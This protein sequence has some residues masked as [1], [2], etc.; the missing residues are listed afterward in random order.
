MR[1]SRVHSWKKVLAQ[2]MLLVLPTVLFFFYLLW[3]LNRFYTILE[4]E[5]V[6][7]GCYFMAGIVITTVFYAYRF[8]F[9]TTAALLLIFYYLIYKYVGSISL[10][11]FDA[12]YLSVQFIVFV[13]LFSLGWLAGFG[14]S[15]SKY[16]TVF[17]SILLLAMQIVVVSKTTDIKVNLLISSFA[18]VLAYA[19][20]I[21]YTAELIRNM[22]EDETHFSS[23]I[24]RRITG[25]LLVLLILF[26]A[27]F[28]IFR[29][30]FKAVEKEWGNSQAKYDK[31]DSKSENMNEKDKDGGIGNKDQTKLSGSLSK[32][33]QLVFV[34]KLDNYFDDNKT[35]NP[36]Y[37]TSCFYTKFDTL[38]Q[39]FERDS[40]MPYNDLY[41]PDPS[42][43]PLYFVKWDSTVLKNTFAT[44]NRKIVTADIYKVMLS[45]SRYLAPST[46]FFCQPMSVPK[47][48]KEQ[49]KSTYRAKM[50]VSDLNSAYFIYNPAGNKMLEQFQEL[51]FNKLREVKK[52]TGP[53]RKF[54][55]YYTYM[56]DNADYKK[57]TAL[58]KQL[59]ANAPT[60]IDKM[61]AIRDYFLSK[62]GFKQPLFKYSD[63]P[64]IPGL[65]SANKLTYFLFE[66]RKGYC[67][68]FAGATLFMLRSL[69][70]PSR[71]AAGYLTVDRS[72]KNPG[73]YWFYANQAHAWVQVYF[74]GY[75]WIDFDTTVPDMNTHQATQPDGTPPTNMPQTF[76]VADGEITDVDDTKKQIKM[77]V[78]KL[79]YHDKDYTTKIVKEM[80]IDVSIATITA[81]TGAVKFSSLK[82]GIHIT[83]VSFD[84]S[85]KNILADKKDSLASIITKLPVPVPIDEVKV[86]SKEEL[87]KLKK[88]NNEQPTEP[89]DWIKVAWTLLLIISALV[90][91]LF[92]SPWII[93][94]Y[95]NTKAK[96]NNNSKAYYSYRASI[97]YLNQLGFFRDNM[98]PQQFAYSMDLKFGSNFNQFNN[99]YQKI[100]YSSLPLSE[101][102]QKLVAEFY[103][104]FIKQ[105][106]S[107]TKFTTRFTK[108]LN[109]YNTTHYFT[110]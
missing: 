46:A 96:L 49:Y 19:F 91:L 12:F 68:Y 100:K 110:T 105:I 65:P 102:E 32:D 14:F 16:F 43:I 41:E 83:A 55:D 81:D 72:S 70:I 22:N 57:I 24:I 1:I 42:R 18:P 73:W 109:I 3:D 25:F 2:L 48:Y 74:Q 5:W 39:T 60:P 50:W 9:I 23:F 77:N 38:T 78:E 104:P 67:A 86:M 30:D 47:E 64:G 69:G 27:V 37:F 92:L 7:Q 26:L 11:E 58:S 103:K 53:D 51:R 79:M 28:N 6:K 75:G 59:T 15:R 35:P 99:V 17:W 62:D 29:N 10:G 56:P 89:I 31:G 40:L 107:K 66:N 76:L 80:I 8:R 45:P 54:M 34:A 13:F 108:F 93:W 71:V 87:K 97:Y 95:F 61:I 88:K 63:N 33:K 84:E 106:R 98:G 20:Y 44:K 82:K 4:N 101:K 94:Q 21:I 90:I 85:L 52:I 36:L